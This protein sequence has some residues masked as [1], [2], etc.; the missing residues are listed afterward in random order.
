MLQTIF[1]DNKIN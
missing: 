1:S